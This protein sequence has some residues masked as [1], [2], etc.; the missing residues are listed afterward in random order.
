MPRFPQ[1]TAVDLYD[2][3]L[4]V[5]FGSN[6][7]RL[8]CCISRAYRDMNRTMREF[9]KFRTAKE[10]EELH[11][12]ASIV[13]RAFL[14]GLRDTTLDQTNFDAR[15]KDVCIDLRTTYAE[16]GFEGFQ[17]G[18]AQKWINM[19]TKYVF[20]FG[21]DRLPGYSWAFELAHVP[22]DNI[23]LD[24]FQNRGL[25]RPKTAWSRISDYDQYMIIQRWIRSSYDGSAPLAVEFALWQDSRGTDSIDENS[26][27][28]SPATPCNHPTPG[29]KD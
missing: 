14:A 16:A 8:S 13:V 1:P 24:C 20:V 28:R 18:Q 27:Q 10:R 26:V 29:V 6:P 19:A 3:L 23:I 21:E 15:H 22:L 25:P 9:R 5:Y 11:A 17:V 12:R 7:D 2:Y 4:R